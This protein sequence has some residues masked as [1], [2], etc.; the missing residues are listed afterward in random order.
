MIL[1]MEEILHQLIGNLVVYPII[2]KHFYTSQV[3][4]ALGFL[5]HPEVDTLLQSAPDRSALLQ[6]RLDSKDETTRF[7]DSAVGP[8]GR[9]NVVVTHIEGLD[10]SG[11]L[12]K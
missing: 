2:Y 8:T 5:H 12:V 1:L 3:V 4:G 9:R 7:E 10:G 11:F 6:M